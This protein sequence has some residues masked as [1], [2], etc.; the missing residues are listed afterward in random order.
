MEQLGIKNDITKLQQL[1]GSKLYSDKYSFI[2]EILQNSTDAMRKCGKGDETF[3]IGIS[4]NSDASNYTFYVRDFGCSFDTIEDFKRLVGTLLESSKTQSKNSSENQEIGKFGIG[5]ISVAAY[6]SEWF[7]KIYKNGKGFDA[8]LMEIEGKGLFL[9]CSE[10][11]DTDEVDGVYFEVI[12]K[13]RPYDFYKN[14]VKKARYFQNINFQFDGPAIAN[15]KMYDSNIVN[16]NES[17]KIYRNDLFQYSTLNKL[18]D[19]HIC[20]DQYSYL[21]RWDILGIDSIKLPIALRFNL[22]DFETNPTRE[23][24]TI[25]D[26][27]KDKVLGKI[28]EV[29]DWFANKYNEL[30]P[31]IE[32]SNLKEFVDEVSKR[33]RKH[34]AIDQYDFDI[35]RIVKEHGTVKLNRAKFKNITKK[36]VKH[37]EEFMKQNYNNYYSFYLKIDNRQGFRKGSI[38]YNVDHILIEGSLKR[39]YQDY[40][41]SNFSDKF[42]FIKKTD[43]KLSFMRNTGF[44]SYQAFLNKD[45]DEMQ[46][47]GV[48]EMYEKIVFLKEQFDEY[49]LRKVSDVFPPDIEEIVKK[50][51]APTTRKSKSVDKTDEDII[52]KYPRR[53]DRYI[54]WDAVWEDKAVKFSELRKQP[55]FHIYGEV[56]D[57]QLL[58]TF[59]VNFNNVQTIMV[60]EKSKKMLDK[61]NLH[62]FVSIDSIKNDFTLISKYATAA[63]I[64]HK[65]KDIKY[66][67]E[68]REL[69]SNHISTG[70]G[71]DIQVLKDLMVSYDIDDVFW[72]S[73]GKTVVKEIINFYENNP[74]MYNQDMLEKLNNVLK[75]AD[76]LDFIQFIDA[77]TVK[78]NPSSL[79]TI[80]DVCRF[81]Q[82]RMNWENYNLDK[83]SNHFQPV[84][85]S[86]VLETV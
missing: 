52:L 30:N 6:N 34:I 54:S 78:N 66:L 74:K 39:S 69:I 48:Y 41:K 10:Y 62:N 13:D 76:K 26:D 33:S 75:V 56:G 2:S 3:N 58:E 42:V 7:Y 9:E 83:I 86:E 47:F 36:D 40:L 49:V 64:A 50:T 1:L 21:I 77:S 81:R 31:E 79:K 67:F 32:C 18:E 46:E 60:T 82:L 38:N 72:R 84:I 17:F 11:Y 20:I 27:Y 24:I 68:N 61:E 28:G 80:R 53:P 22:D 55:K 25:T 29:A 57:R 63:Y 35:T 51:Y 4:F 43:R 73:N 16:V 71:N 45:N 37:F 19:M 70:I 15:L 23:V 85:A 44:G 12:L 5:S 8:K 59:Y 14:L 65:V